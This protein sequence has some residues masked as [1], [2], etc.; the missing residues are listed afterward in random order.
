LRYSSGFSEEDCRR[1]PA[2]DESSI[3]HQVALSGNFTL[4]DDLLQD[5]SEDSRFL[6]K[7]KL[8][9]LV[10]IPISSKEKRTFGVIRIGSN[11][12]KRFTQDQKDVLELIGN[13]IGVAIENAMLQEQVIKS[14]EKYRTLFN[15][16]PHPIF[17]LDSKDF[18]ILDTNKRAQ[19]TY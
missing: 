12:P 18:T 3:I 9:S 6:D 5:R 10:Y 2:V 11:K 19:D 4:Y 13:R 17:I 7:N 15:S 16:D 8:A 1:I 14:E